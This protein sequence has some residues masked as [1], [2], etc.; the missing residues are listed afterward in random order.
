MTR[1]KNATCSCCGAGGP[2]QHVA[3]ILKSDPTVQWRLWLCEGRCLQSESPACRWRY[4]KV[5]EST[6]RGAAA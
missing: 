4:V 3:V 2:L 5:L 1:V 6:R